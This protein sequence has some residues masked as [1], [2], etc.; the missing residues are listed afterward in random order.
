M[1]AAVHMFGA[2]M[3]HI[4]PSAERDHNGHIR[5]QLR[6]NAS[7]ESASAVMSLEEARAVVDCLNAAMAAEVS[8]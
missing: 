8:A 6:I 3:G 1:A 7:C 2:D 4:E 5:L